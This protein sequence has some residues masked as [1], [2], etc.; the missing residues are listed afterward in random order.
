[1][2][3]SNAAY[4]KVTITNHGLMFDEQKELSER[5]VKFNVQEL[6]KAAINVCEGAT[7]CG[8]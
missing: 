2:A 7:N 6:M 1:M 8:L 4:W 3:V 5:Y